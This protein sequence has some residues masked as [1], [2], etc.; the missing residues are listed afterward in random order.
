MAMSEC[1]GCGGG[2][3]PEAQFFPY[4][5][6]CHAHGYTSRDRDPSQPETPAEPVSAPETVETPQS[7]AAPRKSRPKKGTTTT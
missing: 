5:D 6:N 1:A 3:W 2:V 4:C 7:S